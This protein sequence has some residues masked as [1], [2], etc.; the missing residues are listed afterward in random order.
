MVA[1]DGAYATFA[2]ENEQK[3]LVGIKIKIINTPFDGLFN[4][5]NQDDRDI[6]ISTIT[7]C[8]QR[9]QNMDF[10]DPYFVA[11]QLIVLP[12]NSK[13][14]SFAALKSQ[15]IGGQ[16]VTTA[17]EAAQNL[18]GKNS[19]SVERFESMPLAFQEL[20]SGKRRRRCRGRR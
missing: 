6:L 18:N 20:E 19:T 14:T 5:L 10:S 13:V 11:K 8:Q 7:I 12:A 4:A 15:K 17:D 3:Q 1:A 2:P 9:W 16:S